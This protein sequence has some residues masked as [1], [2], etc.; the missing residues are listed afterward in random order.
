[1]PMRT[2]FYGMTIRQHDMFAGPADTS[3]TMTVDDIRRELRDAVAELHTA[4]A[5]PWTIRQLQEART[6]F[7]EFAAHLPDAEAR[8]LLAAFAAELARLGA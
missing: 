4:N 2:D 1:M 7:P 5:L 6:M 3:D 8:P